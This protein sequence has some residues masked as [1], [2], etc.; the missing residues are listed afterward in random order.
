MNS[1]GTEKTRLT[2]RSTHPYFTGDY[3]YADPFMNFGDPH[4]G[5]EGSAHHIVYTV[6]PAKPEDMV[7]M[8][9][10]NGNKMYTN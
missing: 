9:M 5:R 3:A 8:Q 1:D 7:R 2:E 4:A 6:F 10:V